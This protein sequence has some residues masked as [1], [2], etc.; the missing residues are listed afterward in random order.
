MLVLLNRHLFSENGTVI[1][2]ATSK[3]LIFNRIISAS[4]GL[5]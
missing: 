5:I 2:G 4:I 1:N 3:V